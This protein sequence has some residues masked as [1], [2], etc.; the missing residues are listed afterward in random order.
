MSSTPQHVPEFQDYQRAFT[1]H[2][3]D[4]KQHPRPT[5]VT[6]R[7]MRV[8][9][10]L[11]F[12]NIFNLVSSCFPVT[13]RI[14][15]KRK[16]QQLVRELAK[17]SEP[18]FLIYLLHYEWVELAVDISTKEADAAAIDPAGDLCN[19]RP[20]LAPAHMLLSYPYPVHRIGK[21][22]QPTPAQQEQTY[23]LVF[24]D[25]HDEVRFVVLNPVS[26]RLLSLIESGSLTGDQALVQ[27]VEELQHPNPAVALAGGQAMLEELRKEGAILGT[28]RSDTDS[29]S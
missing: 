29:A 24:R 20:V 11:L 18:D 21:R 17:A 2:I 16:W 15:G 26:T 6:A 1:R 22:F 13:R 8:Y 27:V 9:N 5:G 19:G 10:T 4:P 12:N 3:R 14:L 7:R 25:S 28:R 23:L